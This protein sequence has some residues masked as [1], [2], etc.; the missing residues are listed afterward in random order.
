MLKVLLVPEGQEET[1]DLRDNLVSLAK[2][3]RK[4][5]GVLQGY[6]D[7]KESRVFLDHQ[8]CQG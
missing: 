4:G 5:K 8:V 7:P 6:R 2:R 1:K 3:E